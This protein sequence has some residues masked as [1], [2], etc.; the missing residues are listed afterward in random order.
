MS[1]DRP[2][3]TWLWFSVLRIGVF[4]AVLVVLLALNVAPLVAA[5]AAAVIGLCIS[6]IFL[7]G[8]RTRLAGDLRDRL[9]RGRTRRPARS[10]TDVDSDTEDAAVDARQ[11]GAIAPPQQPGQRPAG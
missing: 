10:N 8:P 7:S 1:S 2:R 3:H 9:G 5:I 6:V 11:T 4:F